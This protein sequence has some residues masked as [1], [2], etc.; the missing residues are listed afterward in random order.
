M[1]SSNNLL[2]PVR[3]AEHREVAGVHIDMTRIGSARVRRVV[4]PSGFR[5][6][7]HMK[8]LVGT[9]ACEHAHVGFI[10]AGAIGIRYA[11]GSEKTFTA[12][13]AVGITPGHEGWVVGDEPAIMIEVDFEG[14]TAERFGLTAARA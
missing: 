14:E 3:G 9:S 1:A 5:W 4:Y 11:N 2:A 10:I 7:T 6:S 8:P 13:Q 12:P